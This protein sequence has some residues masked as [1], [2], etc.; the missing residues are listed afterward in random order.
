VQG[1][2]LKHFMIEVKDSLDDFGFKNRTEPNLWF[3]QVIVLSRSEDIIF[4]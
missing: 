4:A 1:T 3:S 2:G